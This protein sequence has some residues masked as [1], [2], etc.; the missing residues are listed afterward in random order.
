MIDSYLSF[1]LLVASIL[2]KYSL[3][4]SFRTGCGARSSP[5][6]CDIRMRMFFLLEHT[7]FTV[8][9]FYVIILYPGSDSWYFAPHLCW[10]FPPQFPSDNFHIF[11]IAKVGTHVED[12]VFR[13]YE[14]WQSHVSVGRSG[15]NE[16]ASKTARQDVMMDVH[17]IATAALCI[18]SYT[19]GKHLCS[20]LY[21]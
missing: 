19:S 14:M 16:S 6:N 8:W 18:L 3:R 15:D 10:V 12:V 21:M 20:K 9:S 17:H 1:Q 11:Y 4:L 2:I 5:H 13:L 7:A